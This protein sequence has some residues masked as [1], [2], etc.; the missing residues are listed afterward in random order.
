MAVSGMP[1]QPDAY[2]H[3]L[4]AHHQSD[5]PLTTWKVDWL[6]LT[7]L[8]GFV[9]ALCVLVFFWIRQY[10][11]TRQRTGVYSV[12]DWSGYATELAGPATSF[13]LLLSAIVVGFAVVLIVGH[14]VW[15]QK[16]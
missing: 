9:A 8:W 5:H 15:G 4:Q 16:F 7:W 2:Y 3:Y 13:F 6:S 14:L 1:K 10:R 11:S 12:D